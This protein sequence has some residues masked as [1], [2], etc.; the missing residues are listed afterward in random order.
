MNCYAVPV[1]KSSVWAELQTLRV[2]VLPV[3]LK[4]RWFSC[5][6]ALLK[7]RLCA[8]TVSAWD[9]ALLKPAQAP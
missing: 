5:C 1:F 6:V 9:R 3:L 4:A 2:T 7:E 8:H